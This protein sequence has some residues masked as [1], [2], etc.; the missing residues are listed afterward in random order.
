[1]SLDQ[2][3]AK[4]AKAQLA[5]VQALTRQTSAPDDFDVSRLQVA[6][7]ALIQKRVRHVERAW[8]S[9]RRA[10]GPRFLDRFAEFAVVSARAAIANAAAADNARGPAQPGHP[11][12]GDG[13]R[14]AIRSASAPPTP[15]VPRIP[16]A[17]SGTHRGDFFSGRRAL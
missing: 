4:L 9:L 13:P 10:F 14:S 15:I 17:P 6:A 11:F 1:M 16:V 8:P 2:A 5:L 3:R 12:V 7:D